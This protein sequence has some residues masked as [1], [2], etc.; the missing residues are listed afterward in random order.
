MSL[1]LFIWTLNCLMREQDVL[2]SV[3]FSLALN[4]KQMTLYYSFPIFW[5]L[6]SRCWRQ[7]SY[8]KSF[9]K[10]MSISTAVILTFAVLWLPYI[11]S[12]DSFLQVLHRIFPIARGIYEVSFQSLIILFI[13]SKC[14]PKG[15]SGK[16]LVLFVGLNKSKKILSRHNFG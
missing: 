15:Q 2:A 13:N 6:L 10:L 12:L 14:T 1:G 16:F 8:L 7:K 4:Y 9:I 11:H 3:L 5:Y